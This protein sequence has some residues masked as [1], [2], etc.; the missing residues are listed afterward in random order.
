MH[1]KTCQIGP[2]VLAPKLDEGEGVQFRRVAD[3]QLEIEFGMD[4]THTHT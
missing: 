4:D 2:T 1:E 3:L